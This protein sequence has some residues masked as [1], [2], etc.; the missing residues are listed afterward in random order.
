VELP[1]RNCEWPKI[2]VILN[3]TTILDGD[4]SD[5]RKNGILDGKDHP[6]LKR[7]KGHIGFLGYGSTV[8]FRNIRIKKL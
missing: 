3:G 4:I 6:G 5:A 2:K 7:D 1:G 8:W